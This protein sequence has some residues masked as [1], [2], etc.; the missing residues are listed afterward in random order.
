VSIALKQDQNCNQNNFVRPLFLARLQHRSKASCG[1]RCFPCLTRQCR[2]RRRRRRRRCS[3]SRLRAFPCELW[4]LVAPG[5]WCRR[6]VGLGGLVEGESGARGVEEGERDK[7]RGSLQQASIHF[8][9]R[10]HVHTHC[11]NYIFCAKCCFELRLLLSWPSRLLL[12]R[13]T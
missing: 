3:R 9:H 6:C 12:R 1:C 10:P 4:W 5:S 13:A 7:Q 2:H 11:V 8:S